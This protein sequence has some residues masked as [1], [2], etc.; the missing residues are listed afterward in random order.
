MI[1]AKAL[2][3]MPVL[4]ASALHGTVLADLEI[5]HSLQDAPLLRRKLSQELNNYLWHMF[6]SVSTEPNDPTSNTV[7]NLALPS[8][9]K[10]GEILDAMES[11]EAVKNPIMGL[12]EECFTLIQAQDHYLEEGLARLGIS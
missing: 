11:E 8:V 12:W 7:L 6:F 9:V 5:S 10:A 3:A 1:Q 2:F 4:N